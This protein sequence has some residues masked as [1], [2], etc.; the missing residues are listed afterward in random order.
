VSVS[1]IN[2]VSSAQSTDRMP[3][4][5]AGNNMGQDAFL[6]LLTTQLRNQD[7]LKPQENGE[8]LA[9]LAQFTSLEKLTSIESSIKE[10]AEAFK[11][12]A[13]DTAYDGTTTDA[14]E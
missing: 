8:F 1:T 5:E 14:G 10:M 13:G 2:G 9:Q 3:G 6:Q 7:P 4:T 12:L 11:T